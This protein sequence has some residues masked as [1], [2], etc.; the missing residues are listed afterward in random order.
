MRRPLATLVLLFAPAALA[1]DAAIA[2]DA[3]FAVVTGKGGAAKGMA[4][5][6][7]IVA[8]G[9]KAVLSYDAADP[10]KS[11][12][13]LEVPVK[14]L[15]VDPFDLEKKHYG[16]L[17]ELGLVA[18]EF[19]DVGDKDRGKIRTSMLDESQ[20]NEAKFPV[21]K[22]RVVRIEAKERPAGKAKLPYTVTLALDL[23]GKTVEK[24]FAASATAAGD[25][26]TVEAV[27]SYKFTEFGIKPYSAFLGAVKVLDDFHVYVRL[28]ATLPPAAPPAEV[29][30]PAETPAAP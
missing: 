9:A 3:L 5:N 2:P 16:R 11:T 17:A 12:F 13:T 30:A 21:V 14:S 6:H 26:L 8:P 18:E 19:A 28:E 1:A 15:Q 4:H 27:G 24:P 23:V 29:A 20:M 10:T 22:A 7:F 25:K